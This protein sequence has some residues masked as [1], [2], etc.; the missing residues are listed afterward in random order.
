ME[1]ALFFIPT[2]LLFLQIEIDYEAGFLL[3]CGAA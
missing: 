2:N 3:L 1:I